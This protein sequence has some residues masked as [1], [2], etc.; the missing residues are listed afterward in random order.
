MQELKANSVKN[1]VAV[2][3]TSMRPSTEKLEKVKSGLS[4]EK[5]ARL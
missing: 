1:T 3:K 2:P 4:M 5:S